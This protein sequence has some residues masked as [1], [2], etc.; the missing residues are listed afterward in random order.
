MF[1]ELVLLSLRRLSFPQTPYLQ[2]L[3][4]MFRVPLKKHLGAGCFQGFFF[5]LFFPITICNWVKSSCCPD[6]TGELP[7][8]HTSDKLLFPR[9]RTWQKALHQSPQFESSHWVSER[10][11]YQCMIL[12]RYMCTTCHGHFQRGWTTRGSSASLRVW[13]PAAAPCDVTLGSMEDH[14]EG[15]ISFIPGGWW[16]GIGNY[17]QK[18]QCGDSDPVKNLTCW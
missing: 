16:D 15:K 1:T 3:M 7:N 13:E 4:D 12:Y 9:G 17:C 18:L 2:W 14:F 8:E 11:R 10:S 6:S 5:F